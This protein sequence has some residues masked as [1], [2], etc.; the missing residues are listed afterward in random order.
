MSHHDKELESGVFIGN[1]VDK[2]QLKNPI[3][4]RL[5]EGFDRAALSALD[6]IQPKNL[7]EAGCG[8][9]RLTRMIAERYGIEVLATD[10][11]NAII[12]ENSAANRNSKIQYEQASVYELNPESHK[13]DTVVCCEVLEHLEE[14]RQGLRALRALEARAYLFSVPHEP[15]WRVLNM[16]R[17]KYWADWGNTP[18][19]L[20]HWSARSFAEI[21][22][23][24][25]FAVERSLNPF[26]WLMAVATPV[27]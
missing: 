14:P 2:S 21:L 10:F 25:G 11:S 19:H 17:G 8:E 3:S 15:I 16:A 7:H 26:P 27:D 9:G 18:G 20:N 4:R 23:G 6:S 5:V 1:Q 22:K 24:E 12:D 13:R